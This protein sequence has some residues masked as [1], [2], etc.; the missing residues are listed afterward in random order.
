MKP[1]I[2]FYVYGKPETAGSKKAFALKKAGAFTGRTVVTDD[3]PKSRAWKTTVSDAAR[4]EYDGEL[5]DCPIYLELTFHL[6]RPASHFGTGKNA[7]RLKDSAPPFPDAKP[8]SVKLTRAV[9]DALTSIIW[10][11]DCLVVDHIIRKRYGS[12]P[13][14]EITIREKTL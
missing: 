7:S 14:V 13:G 11:D 9:E 2:N 8:D 5:W 1:P 4:R 3:N 6:A 10:R 12:R